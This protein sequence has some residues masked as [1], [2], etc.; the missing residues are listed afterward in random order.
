MRVK[1]CCIQSI[2]EARLAAAAGAHLIGLVGRMPSGPGP[3]ADDRIAEVAGW[4]PPGLGA[5]LLSSET[6][7]DGL[8]DH[9]RR[10]GA[11]VL[12]IVDA[13]APGARAA[14]RRALPSLRLMQV[15]HVEDEGAIDAARAAAPEVDAILLDSGRPSAAVKELGG[16][17]RTHDWSVSARLVAAVDRP[18]F[19]AGGL[20]AG[21]VGAA[22]R[23]VR[24]WGVDIC[25]GVRTDDALDPEKLSAFMAAVRAAS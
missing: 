7:A 18:V 21:N 13:P 6:E 16:T 12:Q 11:Q 9:A 4:A 2:A 1:I 10:T 24:P 5:A 3:I 15:I 8:I 19:L 22:I 23:A 20:N 25:S 14:L 17:G